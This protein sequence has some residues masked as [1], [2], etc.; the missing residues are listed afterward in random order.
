MAP[1]ERFDILIVGAGAAGAVLARRLSEG[2]QR[3]VALVE[4]G[5]DPKEIPPDIRDGTRN[6]MKEHDWGLAHRPRPDKPT[7]MYP[8]GRI[9]GGSSAVNT[10]I[11][12]RGQRYDFDEWGLPGWSWDECLEAFC[13]IETDQDFPESEIHGHEGPI[14]VR[15]H[16][17]EE[18]VPWQAAFIDAAQSL[19]FESCDDHNDLSKTGVGP[20]AMNKIA[21]ERMNAARCYLDDKVR[22]RSSLT[23]F[24][25]SHVRRVLFEGQRA[26]GVE[27]EYRGETVVHLAK[28][29]ILSGGAIGTPGILIRSGVGPRAQLERL[30]IDVV[31]DA[32]VGARLL[33]HPGVT[34]FMLAKPGVIR[35]SDPLI[36]T[37]LRYTARNSNYKDEMQL[38]PGSFVPLPTGDAPLVMIMT[39]IGK[40]S[41]EGRIFFESADPHARPRIESDF[42]LEPDDLEKACE[43][44]ELAWL[45]A[46]SPA[47]RELA[48]FAV[49]NERMFSSRKA[50][51]EWIPRQTGSGYHPCGTVKMG[52]ASDPLAVTDER[53]RVRGVEGLYVADA[54]L[55]PTVPSS[56]THFPTL[57]LGERFAQFFAD[58]LTSI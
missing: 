1:T 53:G 29:V 4:A 26:V 27:V 21:G 45:C 55:F 48:T 37:A 5:P 23:I 33:D 46:S 49:P 10:C 18:L 39:S 30:G 12:L 58:G 51:R 40:P 47:M 57:M 2:G 6:S 41:G 3:S 9:V 7:M 15:R 32:P 44:M 52:E 56:N 8:R 11:A 43:A 50:L 17:Q 14:P 31:K 19:G 36:Q 34:M 38:Q 24:S 16:T 13:N 25:D 20:H 22:A 54:S 35:L 28:E 42:L